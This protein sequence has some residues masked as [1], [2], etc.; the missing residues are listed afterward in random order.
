VNTEIVYTDFINIQTDNY[1]TLGENMEKQK[2]GIKEVAIALVLIFFINMSTAEGNITT[3]SGNINLLPG[4]E[5]VVL[6]N[7]KSLYVRNTAGTQYIGISLNTDGNT[8]F[9][10]GLTRNVL[11]ENINN[12]FIYPQNAV[13]EVFRMGYDPVG[14]NGSYFVFGGGGYIDGTAPTH[15]SEL[16]YFDKPA[17]NFLQ[18][19]TVSGDIQFVSKSGMT[20]FNNYDTS[21]YYIAI[22]TSTSRP[23]LQCYASNSCDIGAVSKPFGIGYFDD[24]QVLSRG[25]IGSPE[26]AYA[27]VSAIRTMDNGEID[28]TTVD[29][30]L[31][32]DSGGAISIN[33]VTFA[34]SKAITHLMQKI[35]ALEEENTRLNSRIVTL[36]AKLTDQ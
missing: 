8:F 15:F 28:H 20:K 29:S 21:G 36:E 12:M 2:R 3:T 14:G 33:A 9:T 27:S 19:K 30:S 1:I 10:Q 22:N 5:S 4:G 6:G 16:S 32:D 25:Y 18:F 26:K 23:V 13:K 11:F 35:K 31:S 17:E 34:N 7:G 24:I